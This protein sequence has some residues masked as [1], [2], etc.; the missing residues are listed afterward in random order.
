MR[1]GAGHFDHRIEISSGDELERLADRFNTMAGELALSQDRSERISRLKRFLAPQVAELV[2][3]SGQEALLDSSRTEVVVV[4]C[5]LRSFTAFASQADA[6][7]VMG[8]L[9]QYYEALG[10]IITRYEATVTNIAGD[11][12]MMLLNAP[13]PMPDAARIG[14]EM[15]AD[16]QW[17]VQDLIL[18]WQAR[19]YRIGFGIGLAKGTATVG[20]IGYEGRLDYTA[21]GSVVN[22]AARLCAGAANGQ[23]LIDAPTAAGLAGAVPVAALGAHQI[24]GFADGIAVYDIAW[25]QM[26]ASSGPATAAS[27][28]A[29]SGA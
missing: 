20:R 2:E 1:I 9:R 25:K 26:S 27:R 7:E 5:D 11:G 14:A 10:A 24:K 19:G 22:L 15:A 18:G 13:M 28:A 4:F 3:R 21:I 16:M 6:D 29:R 8:L 12:L 17:A 23:I